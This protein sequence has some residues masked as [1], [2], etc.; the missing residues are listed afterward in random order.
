MTFNKVKFLTVATLLSLAACSEPEADPVTLKPHDLTDSAVGHFCGMIVTN[1]KGPKGQVFL[2][3]KDEPYWFVSVQDT[4]AFMRLPENASSVRA[5]YVTDMG[6]ADNWD[7]PGN[8][9]WR[10]VDGLWFVT[11]STRTG[12]MGGKSIVPFQDKAMAEAFA[13]Q[14]G[15]TLKMA[16]EIETDSLLG[17]TENEAPS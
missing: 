14:Y 3:G 9:S 6:V 8:M 1:H 15:G 7:N 16:S 5:A 4:L 13:A 10:A 2:K 12:G 11:E 17:D